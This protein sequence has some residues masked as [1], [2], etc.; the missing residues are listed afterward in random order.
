MKAN[1][2]NIDFQSADSNIFVGFVTRQL[3]QKLLN[4]G[5]L[6]VLQ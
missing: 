6:V 1:L 3:V 4:D 2:I 5:D